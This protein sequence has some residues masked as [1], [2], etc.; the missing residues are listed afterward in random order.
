[1]L[2]T[3]TDGVAADTI[4]R[5]R[6][7]LAQNTEPEG[8]AIPD[9]LRA[10]PLFVLG[11][12][13]RRI[14][15]PV[16]SEYACKMASPV[17]VAE[18]M[19]NGGEQI[20]ADIGV[21]VL[22]SETDEYAGGELVIDT[23]WGEERIKEKAGTCIVYP[24]T[25]R[26]GIAEVTQGTLWIARLWVQSLV[27]HAWQREILYDIGYSASVLEVFG[28]GRAGALETLQRC[29]RNLLRHWARP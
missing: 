15:D 22:L 9:A 17:E 28:G 19:P 6:S 5:L 25:A 8:S 26:T 3:L 1:M 27:I 18:A 4:T 20:R 7:S 29:R 12:E 14:S 23:G 16:F 10:N 21:T 2:L 13:P 24:A 11:V